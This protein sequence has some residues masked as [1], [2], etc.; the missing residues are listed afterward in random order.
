MV[1]IDRLFTGSLPGITVHFKK[2]RRQNHK[3]ES[4]REEKGKHERERENRYKICARS[5]CY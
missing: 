3:K 1:V 5:V 2:S 4:R